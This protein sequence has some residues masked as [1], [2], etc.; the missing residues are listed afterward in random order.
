[1]LATK[2]H[3]P[4]NA[5]SP[6]PEFARSC[7][8]LLR[9]RRAAPTPRT[10]VGRPGFLGATMAVDTGTMSTTM[11][12][13]GVADAMHALLVKPADVVGPLSEWLRRAHKDANGPG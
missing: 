2:P 11:E 10:R 6:L 8:K 1:M 4:G 13:A 7:P 9:E 12:L 3:T 5:T